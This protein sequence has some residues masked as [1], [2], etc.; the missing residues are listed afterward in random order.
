MEKEFE[1]LYWGRHTC[2]DVQGEKLDEI[3]LNCDVVQGCIIFPTLFNI[4]TEDIFTA[5][6]NDLESIHRGGAI[7]SYIRYEE[8]E[9][10]Q[11]EYISNA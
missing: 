1:T 4:Y 3:S 11:I 10:R 2:I 5:T 6:L 8:K 9:S 7:I